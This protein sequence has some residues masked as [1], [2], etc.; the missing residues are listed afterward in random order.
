[1]PSEAD[2]ITI[3]DGLVSYLEQNSESFYTRD[4]PI[5]E[6]MDEYNRQYIGILVD[7]KRI[8]Y[9]NYFCDSAQKDWTEEFILVMDGGDCFF[10][11]QYDVDTAEY[12]NLQVN[13]SA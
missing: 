5:W 1:M 9:A 12:F 8:V 11:F 13:G 3:Q 2:V 6:R 4:I 10:Q 7:G